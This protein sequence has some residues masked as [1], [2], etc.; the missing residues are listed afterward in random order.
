[1]V[2]PVVFQFTPTKLDYVRAIR[3]YYRHQ[4]T[5]WFVAVLFGSLAVISW[6]AIF[7]LKADLTPV[8]VAVTLFLG[9]FLGYMFVYA[10]WRTGRTIDQTERMRVPTTWRLHAQHIEVETPYTQ[11]TVDWGTFHKVLVTKD[12]Y[13]FIYATNKNLFQIVPRRALESSAHVAAFEQLVAQHL[14]S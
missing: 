14:P 2:E 13:L 3:A 4:P 9:F 8:A 10:P 7:F 11:A 1:M 5:T 12:A 6:A